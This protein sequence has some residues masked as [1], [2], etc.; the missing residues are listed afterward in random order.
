[1]RPFHDQT[2]GLRMRVSLEFLAATH[3]RALSLAVVDWTFE[4]VLSN[5]TYNNNHYYDGFVAQGG[6]LFPF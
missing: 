4:Y 2:F 6:V 1:M 3:L 5:N